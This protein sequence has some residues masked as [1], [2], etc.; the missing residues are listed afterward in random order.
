MTAVTVTP[1]TAEAGSTVT[2]NGAAVASGSASA[3]LPPGGG[4]QPAAGGGD[5][6]D[7]RAPRLR[8]HG[9]AGRRRRGSWAAPGGLAAVPGASAGAPLLAVGWSAP[10]GTVSGYAVQY[11]PQPDAAEPE[12]AW[13]DWPHAG[14]TSATLTGLRRGAAYEVRVAALDAT[15]AA[16]AWAVARAAAW[17][18]PGRP[19]EL[20]AAAGP[21]RLRVTWAAQ[22]D[23][24]APPA[25]YR[26][27]WRTAALGAGQPGAWQGAAGADPDGEAV[28]GT[29]YLITGLDDGVAYDVEVRALNALGRGPNAAVSATPA[30]LPGAPPTRLR[31]APGDRRL[32]LRWAAPADDGGAPITGWQARV[33]RWRP[34][35]AIWTSWSAPQP[36]GSRHARHTAA[37]LVNGSRHEAQVRAVNAQGAGRDG[38]AGRAGGG[39]GR[40]GQL[41]GGAGHPSG[42]R[43]DGGGGQQRPRGGAREPGAADLRGGGLERAAD[44]DGDRRAGRRRRRRAGDDHAR[45]GRLRRG[46]H[47]AGGDGGGRRRRGRT[48]AAAGDAGRGEDAQRGGSSEPAREGDRVGHGRV[49]RDQAGGGRRHGVGGRLG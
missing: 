44:G 18:L 22:D 33:R 37:G 36:T 31:A 10:A 17:D 8:G 32:E 34:V 3:A 30:R 9:D 24:G 4:R 15:D 43:G 7:R 38:G 29:A 28:T 19:A 35:A 42:R 49:P 1:V 46:A 25:G 20:A 48:A 5:R 26:V 23:G 12:P 11:R 21:G 13:S 27:R 47:G 39:R 40:G 14:G 16:G 6:G 45:G 41:H 2:V